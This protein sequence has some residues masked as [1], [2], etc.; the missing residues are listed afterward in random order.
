VIGV[1][2]TIA[3]LALVLVAA[4]TVAATLRIGGRACFALAVLVFAAA[5]IVACSTALSPIHALTRVGMFLA[6]VVLAAAGLAVWLRAGRPRPP[7]FAPASWRPQF[8]G[9][10]LAAVIVAG[11]AMLV[12]FYILS[13]VAPSNW[14]SMAYH[15]SRAAY[16][17]QYHSVGQ[18]PGASVN[19]RSSPPDAEILLAWTMLVSGTDRWVGIVQ[20]LSLCGLA[21]AIYGGARFV[22]LPA[23]GAAFAA[24]LFVLLPQPMLQ[25]TSTQNDLVVSLF[26]AAAALFMVRGLRDGRRAELAVA[27]VAL[28][29]A[30]GTKGTSFIALPALGLFAVGAVVAWRP[31]RALVLWGL[32]L[33]LAGVVVFGSYNYILNEVNLGDPFGGVEQ[34]AGID[35]AATPVAPPVTSGATTPAAPPT[36]PF[37]NLI[38]DEWTL[39]D[40][41]GTVIPWLGPI[42]Q[43]AGLDLFGNATGNAF[44]FTVDTSVDEDTSGFGLVGFLVMPLLLLLAVLGRRVP[45]PQRFVGAGALLYLLLVGIELPYNPW[46]GRLMIPAFAIGA[47]LF[48]RL[49]LRPALAGLVLG[50]AVLSGIPAALQNQQAPVLVAPGAPNVFDWTR[51]EQMTVVRPDMAP[52]IDE[53]NQMVGMHARIGMAAGGNSWDYPFFGAHR[54][55]YLVRFLYPQEATAAVMRR[56][57]LVATVFLDVGEPSRSLHPIE[58]GTGDRWLVWTPA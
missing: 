32:G 34:L 33:A 40:S 53:V 27:A 16:W 18:F 46:L 13:H 50:L 55:R 57:H 11:L 3:S 2:D 17:L 49:I 41:P 20:W 25:S 8:G 58:L 42:V 54:T 38:E 10:A 19:Q 21:I 31:R 52:V 48:G 35:R 26:I 6:Q 47:P 29:L 15:L 43:R 14:D 9:A 56:D 23:A 5:D 36:Y 45:L 44:P 30:I 28:G 1:L 12:Q 4:V 7:R 39:V 37:R 22:R 51:T 24:A